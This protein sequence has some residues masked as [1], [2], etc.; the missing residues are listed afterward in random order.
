MSANEVDAILAKL[1][2]DKRDTLQKLRETVRAA[3]PQADEA[4]SYGVPALRYKDKPLVS[5][6]SAKEHCAFYVMSPAV[7]QANRAAL[8]E[9]D[10]DKG[11]IRFPVGGRLPATLV[12]KLVKARMAETDATVAKKAKK[13]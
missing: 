11:T 3:A 8:K 5:Y 4:L 6:N 1:P 7:M 10:T 13:K 12:R 2:K 9:Y